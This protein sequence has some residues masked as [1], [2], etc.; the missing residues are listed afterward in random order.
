MEPETAPAQDLPAWAAPGSVRHTVTVTA[1]TT[2]PVPGRGVRL[3]RRG[4]E[5]FVANFEPVPMHRDHGTERIGTNLRAWLEDRDDGTTALMME[6]EAFLP[7]DSDPT[8]LGKGWSLSF[9]ETAR[10]SDETPI[11]IGL[12]TMTFDLEAL[13][14]AQKALDEAPIEV[15][16]EPFHQFAALPPPLILILIQ[17]AAI[18]LLQG[19]AASAIWDALKGAIGRLVT[20]SKQPTE[21]CRVRVDVEGAIDAH[22]DVTLPVRPE[23]IDLVLDSVFKGAIALM[24]ASTDAPAT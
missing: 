20:R 11:V 16:V 4:L 21:P 24:Q 15:V 8:F 18:P 13:E 2:A 10:H 14:Q 9:M 12:D 22:I 7:P 17:Q 3:D 19:V 1:I 5:S 23:D 6:G